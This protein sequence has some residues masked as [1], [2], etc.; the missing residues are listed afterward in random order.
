[1]SLLPPPIDSRSDDD[2]VAQVAMLAEH[3][4]RDFTH[5]VK[6]TI[7]DLLNRTLDQEIPGIASVG[8]VLSLALA[9]QISQ[10]KDLDRV[11]VK[12]GW[13]PPGA[14]QVRPAIASLVGRILN[15][16][17]R[18]GETLIVSRGSPIDA[19]LAEQISQIRDLTWVKVRSQPGANNIEPSVESLL[20]RVLNQDIPNP[21]N[22]EQP[23]AIRG[24]VIDLALAERISAQDLQRVSVK[25]LPDAGWGLI[26]IFARMA[27]LVR[28]RVNQVPDKNFLAFLDLI[29]TQLLPPQAARVPLTFYLAEGTTSDIVVPAHTQVAA[30]G[31]PDEVIFETEHD[32]L[33]TT[34]QLE[35]VF[36]HEPQTNCLS[37]R[38]A[39]ALGESDT[40]FAAFAAEQAIEQSL[41]LACEALLTLPGIKSTV[42]LLID[43]PEAAQ[44]SALSITWSF[45]NGTIWQPISARSEMVS[46]TQWRVILTNLPSLNPHLL[47]GEM[48]GK[49]AGWLRGQI[50]T[51]LSNQAP[52]VHIEQVQ[53]QVEMVRSELKPDRCFFNTV[54]IDLSKDFYPFGEQPRFN[55][56]FYIASNDAF[57]KAATAVTVQID[58]SDGQAINTGGGI[59]LV[60]ESWN[61]E[62]WQVAKAKSAG[63]KPENLTADNPNTFE[64]TLPATTV[65]T[66]VNGETHYWVRARIAKGNYGT[67]ASS[68]QTTNAEGRPVF[69]L[70][71]ASFQPPSLTSLKLSYRF[72]S[73][74][75][76][77]SAIQAYDRL[78]YH[79]P[80]VISRTTQLIQSRKAGEKTLKLTSVAGWIVGDRIRMAGDNPEANEIISIDPTTKIVTVKSP[81]AQPHTLETTVTRDFQPF[82]PVEDQRPTL[83]LGF[84]QPF[85]NRTIS[86]YLQVEPP[87]PGDITQNPRPTEPAQVIWEHSTPI[88]WAR[89]DVQD[90]TETFSDRGLIRFIGPADFAGRTEFGQSRY[91]LR[92]RWESGQF[93]VPPR[94]RR[95]LTNTLWAAQ[96][97]THTHEVLGSSTGNPNQTFRS[98]RSPILANQQLAVIEETEETEVPWQEVSDFYGSSA[99][100]RHYTLDRFTGTVQF[101][102][103]QR[104]KVPPLGQNNVQLLHYRTGGGTQ[105]NLPAQTIVQ[106]KTTVPSIDRVT[107]LEAAGGGANREAMERVKDRGPKRLRHR[108][109]AVT[110]QDLEDLAFE[111]SPAVA[112]A[113]AITPH[114]DPITLQW[115]PSYPIRI[116]QPGEIQVAIA[117]DARSSPNLAL[118]IILYGPA[119]SH[120]YTQQTIRSN[121]DRLRFTV[122]EEQFKLGTN[123]KVTVVNL[124][125]SNIQGNIT[126]TSPNGSQRSG[127]E[128]PASSANREIRDAGKVELLIV[129]EST[130]AQPTPSL[131]LINLVERYLRDRATP[132]VDLQVTEPDWVEV[133]VSAEIVPASLDVADT[134]QTA[135]RAALTRFLHPLTGG[136]NQQGW[137]FGRRP[138]PS[139]FYALLETIP[140]ID[141]VAN[142]SLV[143]I[144]SLGDDSVNTPLP[145]DRLDRFLI[146]SGHHQIILP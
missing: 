45:W 136:A 88:G 122:T 61:G 99:E 109:R 62:A 64:I 17:I 74:S 76:P 28:D 60:W 91:W 11:K 49:M 12:G 32:L 119:Q 120:P 30:P 140:E 127:L 82:M 75:V 59:E 33:A 18:E 65:Q 48:D 29:G 96:S 132:T 139:D 50:T 78:T 53:V 68:A 24:T 10:L 40:P 57:A 25:I 128:V 71:N 113:K 44:L 87:S 116:D 98:T 131:A 42:T 83:Y 5:D 58:L 2:I 69:T 72:T 142:L 46:S 115:F 129:P 108:D 31:D 121:Q 13:Y 37:D 8:T 94:F 138:F 55:D 130:A 97:A 7:P 114:F 39:A 77:V 19:A 70:T 107:N 141:H 80:L 85:A 22:R 145:A 124:N 81:L 3:F 92:C 66:A 47:N 56:T 126:L 134:A 43:S 93:R 144:P 15:Q 84:D 36:V 103:G 95:L 105:G 38:T 112:R 20:G 86:L 125:D 14:S 117:V 52:R 118:E 63:N 26:R 34:A 146:Y 101:G 21:A 41:Y 100:D 9:R 106:M 104:G 6:P 27:A 35:A 1:M 89:L 67:A 23:I 4:T 143:S 135:A 73:A 51:A 16:D 102:N 90:E 123:W 111:A 79:D 133:T 137:L 110:A 54:P